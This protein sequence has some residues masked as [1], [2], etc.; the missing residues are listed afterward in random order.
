MM[1]MNGK[2]V[3]PVAVIA[4]CLFVGGQSVAA[5]EGYKSPKTQ[6]DEQIQQTQTQ[7]GRSHSQFGQSQMQGTSENRRV[8]NLMDKEVQGQNQKKLGKVSDLI[9]N[10]QGQVEYL[11]ISSGGIAGLGENHTPIPWD[12]VQQ[13]GQEDALVVNIDENQLK[14]APK[15]SEKTFDQPEWQNEVRGYY[16]DG[17][18]DS[19]ENIRFDDQDRG[20]TQEDRT[21][22]DQDSNEPTDLEMDKEDKDPTL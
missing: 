13:S 19:Q 21:Y 17:Q 3:V 18:Q 11:I 16:G 20:G 12:S 9:V 4:G 22:F 8:S 15:F 5:G 6:T 1:K 7:K 10:G 2:K 14:N